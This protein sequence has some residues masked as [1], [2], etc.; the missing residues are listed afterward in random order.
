[1][2]PETALAICRFCHDASAMVLWGA[3]GYL[4]ALVPRDLAETVGHHLA[5]FRLCAVALAVLGTAAIL[6][7]EV[8]LV[9]DR[10]WHDVFD[11]ATVRSVLFETNVGS[12]WLVQAAAALLL[13]GTMLVPPGMRTAATATGA[14]L[15][16][17]SLA[18]TGHAAMH[19]GWLGILH[20][21]ND[22]THVLAGGAWLGA[23]VPLLLIL[24]GLNNPSHRCGA[25]IA[26]RRFSTAG[27]AAVAL[28]I[29]TGVANTA[30]VLGRWPSVWSSSYQDMLSAK[31][32]LVLVMTVLA[33]VNRYAIVPRIGGARDASLRALRRATLA[34]IVLGIAVVGL[35]AV[36]GLLEPA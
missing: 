36:F 11:P 9:G 18:S 33:L 1:M 26:L 32:G 13:A 7:V 25:G 31:L 34:E 16:L 14:G 24:K 3:Y 17:A 10:G 6:P 23:L 5:V 22:A 35:V 19:E 20:R 21:L 8:A 29:A 30:L 27:H 2:D 15:V 28:V 4:A 12:A